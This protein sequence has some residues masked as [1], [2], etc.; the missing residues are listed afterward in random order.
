MECLH[1][2]LHKISSVVYGLCL[3]M[4]EKA[5]T[6]VELLVGTFVRFED[7]MDEF[8]FQFRS[9]L[10]RTSWTIVWRE[11]ERQ[12]ERKQ[13]A[14]EAIYES[15]FMPT[16][17]NRCAYVDDFCFLSSFLFIDI[18]CARVCL[19]QVPRI[20]LSSFHFISFYW[21]RQSCVSAHFKFI[22]FLDVAVILFSSRLVSWECLWNWT[23]QSRE[24]ETK[25]CYASTACEWVS[26][27][28]DY[29]CCCCSSRT[30]LTL[31]IHHVKMIVIIY[32]DIYGRA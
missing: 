25:T 7:E 19:L 24:Q 32:V 1:A 8:L 21:E 23:E 26:V 4:I 14:F 18:V 30:K 6:S 13:I 31:K 2:Y 17:D 28:V 11:N 20:S 15:I 27:C 22:S 10:W 12:K 3:R 16:C 9:S 5:R 29:F